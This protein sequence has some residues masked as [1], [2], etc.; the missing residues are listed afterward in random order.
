MLIT[1]DP[2]SAQPLFDQIATAV[3]VA[4]VRGQARAGERLPSARELA[5]SLGLNVN[6]VLHAYRELRSEGLVELHRGRGAVVSPRAAQDYEA[7]R[8]ALTDVAAEGRRLGLR[9][10]SI[11]RLLDSE[12]E[13]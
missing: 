10:G 13:T 1:V 6:T 3:R 8:R 2:A 5:M 11:A 4:V 9:P 7:L 12:E